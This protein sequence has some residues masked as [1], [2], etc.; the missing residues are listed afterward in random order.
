MTILRAALSLST[1]QQFK[2][3]AFLSS[4]HI[5]SHSILLW[6]RSRNFP[7]NSALKN[8]FICVW[9]GV[10]HSQEQSWWFC[11]QFC[12]PFCLV[13]FYPPH[14]TLPTPSHLQTMHCLK[15][16]AEQ[17][18]HHQKPSRYAQHLSKSSHAVV[19]HLKQLQCCKFDFRR[20][21]KNSICLGG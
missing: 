16:Q 2:L 5:A 21:K 19:K 12:C 13:S 4:F 1:A 20:W 14:H 18:C 9:A 8:R 6:K 17:I 3:G 15:H 10:G 7:R 11:V